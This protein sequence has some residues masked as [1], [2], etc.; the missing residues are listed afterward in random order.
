MEYVDGGAVSTILEKAADDKNPIAMEEKIQKMLLPAGWGIEYLHHQKIV[1]RD[2]A[3]RNCLY[4][5]DKVVSC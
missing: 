5:Q 2:I 4:S 3:A 1:H